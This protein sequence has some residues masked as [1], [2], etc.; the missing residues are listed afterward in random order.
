[1]RESAD[2]TAGEAR[3]ISPPPPSGTPPTS[4]AASVPDTMPAPGMTRAAAT[5]KGP[6][7]CASC[8]K[9]T[10][11]RL[12]RLRCSNGTFQIKWQCTECGA[13]TSNALS[14]AAVDYPEHLEGWDTTLESRRQRQVR[15]LNSA[16]LARRRAEYRQYLLT[17]EW[18][19]RRQLV[20]EREGGMC[21]GC[22]IEPAAEVHH[23]TYAHVRAEFL[24]E[25]VAL[26]RPCHERIEG[27]GSPWMLDG[28]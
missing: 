14:H 21:Q 1:M 4:S 7:P 23:L 3:R 18:R 16:D 8:A 20:M 22:R 17:P 11:S 25:L 28:E 6:R 15:D 19:A 27:I 2:G 10:E 13:A 12:R 24:F 26:C 5:F 9:V